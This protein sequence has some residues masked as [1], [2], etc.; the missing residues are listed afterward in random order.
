M[1]QRLQQSFFLWRFGQIPGQDLALP[2]F[3]IPLIG[4]ITLGR[5]PLN[6]WSARRRDCY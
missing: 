6:E 3:A 5:T 4:H 1:N 2:S